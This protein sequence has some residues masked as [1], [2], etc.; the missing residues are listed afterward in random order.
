[1]SVVIGKIIMLNVQ[2]VMFI[3]DD[4]NWI[5]FKIGDE[6]SNDEKLAW[7]I[8]GL[9]KI[10]QNSAKPVVYR[11][12]KTRRDLLKQLIVKTIMLKHIY[13]ILCTC[14]YFV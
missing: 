13:P 4:K 7:V 9:L 5:N 1:M 11:C 14:S 2:D 3:C 12:S 8:G 10:N 6:I